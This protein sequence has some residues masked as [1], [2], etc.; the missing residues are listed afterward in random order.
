MSEIRAT[1]DF[2][3]PAH[4]VRRRYEI[5]ATRYVR[6]WRAQIT[7]PLIEAVA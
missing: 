5:R 6:L 7:D 4:R 3:I 2:S 1:A